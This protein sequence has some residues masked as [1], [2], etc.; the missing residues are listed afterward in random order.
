MVLICICPSSFAEY[1]NNLDYYGALYTHVQSHFGFKVEFEAEESLVERFAQQPFQLKSAHT[2][3][4]TLNPTQLEFM[5]AVSLFE[6]SLMTKKT[7]LYFVTLIQGRKVTGK[8]YKIVVTMEELN[9]CMILIL[10]I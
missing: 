2:N 4:T 8:S 5:F 3:R 1:N 10:R 6:A 7:S 9:K